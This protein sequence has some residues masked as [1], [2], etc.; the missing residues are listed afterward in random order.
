MA[1]LMGDHDLMRSE[2]GTQKMLRLDLRR[3]EEDGWMKEVE[4]D[5]RED[6]R[7]EQ[8]GIERERENKYRNRGECVRRTDMRRAMNSSHVSK[9]RGVT[10]TMKNKTRYN[11]PRVG[12]DGLLDR[13]KE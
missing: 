1:R 6:A 13:C 11:S 7:V 3:V 10:R 4:L 12:G 8:M 2:E 9:G 5:V